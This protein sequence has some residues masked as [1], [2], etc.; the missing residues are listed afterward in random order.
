MTNRPHQTLETTQAM[1]QRIRVARGLAPCDCLL[2]NVKLVN[3]LTA[4]IYPVDAVA[5]F[6]GLIVG[7][8][9]DRE[10]AQRIDLGGQ[11]LAPAFVDGHVHIE[12]SMVTPREFA[13]A[14]VPNG[15]LAVVCDPH[16]IAN[17]LGADGVKYILDAS[18]N[19]PLDVYVMIPSCVPA[20]PLETAGATMGADVV[21]D[22]LDCHPRVLGL[23]EMMNFPGVLN[24]FDDPLQKLAAAAARQ[25]RRDGHA[26]LVRGRDLSAYLVAGIT[27][28]H[29]STSMQEAQDKLRQG[30]MLQI[31][32][33]SAAKNLAELLRAVTPATA[34]R[35]M[36]VTDDRHPADLLEDGHIN[37]VVRDAI[38][39]GVQPSV[40]LSMGSTTAARHYRLDPPRGAVAPGY[41]ADLIAFES[42]DTIKPTHVFRRGVLVAKDGALVVELPAATASAAT[43]TVR[44]T[45]AQIPDF[46]VSAPSPTDTAS[47]ALRVIV[48]EAGSLL[49]GEV[50]VPLTVAET[51]NGRV[52]VSDTERDVLKM[53]VL[54][55]HTGAARRGVGFVRGLGLKR[56]ALGCSVAHDSHNLIAVGATDAEIHT[57]L[58]ELIAMQ[59]GLVVVDGDTVLEKFPLP[60]AGLMSADTVEAA[61]DAEHA[62]NRAARTLGV[63]I[64]NPFMTLSFLALP[65]IPALKLTDHGLVDVTQF[66][67]VDLFAPTTA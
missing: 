52:V 48:A 50:R 66:A 55:R 5:I 57:A 41:A 43:A 27:T 61:R 31:R 23:A 53:V 4:E 56:G 32:E 37:A 15:T 1:A 60:V 28:D 9:A 8:G 63:T 13:R 7:F 38:R 51:A 17:V 40:A 34:H 10:A 47:D 39:H 30:M 44:L 58:A 20:T 21:A 59:G 29:E 33:G 11:F 62:L 46:T 6:S 67:V 65:P 49:T 24:G 45:A 35:C 36:F 42:L 18:E 26:P 22:L 64:P 19:L 16:E 14:V 54:E 3:T 25:R 12:S 2:E